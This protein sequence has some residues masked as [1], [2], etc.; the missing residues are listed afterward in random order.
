[1]RGFADA[2]IRICS[3]KALRFWKNWQDFTIAPWQVDVG[4]GSRD[5]CRQ[6]LQSQLGQHPVLENSLR[7]SVLSTQNLLLTALHFYPEQSS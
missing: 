3:D 7:I 6:H 5:N 1:M 2:G 4:F